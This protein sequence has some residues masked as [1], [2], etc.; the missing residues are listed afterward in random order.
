MKR[1]TLLVV[2]A[3]ATIVVG[4]K[5]AYDAYRENER[6]KEESMPLSG[7]ICRNCAVIKAD[8]KRLREENA[9]RSL[10]EKQVDPRR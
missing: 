2:I 3:L 10:F 6:P 7:A 4:G 5:I 9:Q 1:R 8:L